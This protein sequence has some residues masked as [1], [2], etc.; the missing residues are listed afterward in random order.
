MSL[1]K[2]PSQINTEDLLAA[3]EKSEL[4]KQITPEVIEYKNDILPFISFYEITP[5]AF[6]VYRKVIYNLY[7]QW[8]KD[9]V[10]SKVFSLEICKY[11]FSKQKNNTKYYY[12]INISAFK[13]AEKSFKLLK[14]QTIDRKKSP[15]YQK[16]FNAFLKHYDIHSG[17]TYIPFPEI[18]HLY[19]L[20]TFKNNKK[21]MAYKT[22]HSFCRLNFE[23]KRIGNSKGV[24]FALNPSI[25]TYINEKIK[26]ETYKKD[27]EE[28]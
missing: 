24:A 6:P 4:P 25:K 2:L 3:L 13:L 18:Y 19:D 7:K 23:E 14:K 9:P 1:K 21:P 15:I 22:V 5:G 26:K 27:K 20:W 17:K 12:Y 8:S 10:S 11:I 16:H 28:K